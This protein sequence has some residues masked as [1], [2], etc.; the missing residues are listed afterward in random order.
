MLVTHTAGEATATF[1]SIL[2]W[3]HSVMP[4]D[5]EKRHIRTIGSSHDLSVLASTCA[6]L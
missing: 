1:I 4:L 3:N 5:M 2:V 6:G